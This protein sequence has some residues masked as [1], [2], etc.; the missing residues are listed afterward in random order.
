MLHW[1]RLN[2]QQVQGDKEITLMLEPPALSSNVTASQD[3]SSPHCLFNTFDEGRDT[4][5]DIASDTEVDFML[6]ENKIN[7]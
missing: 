4:C 7:E 3:L 6:P 2:W 1:T 5:D